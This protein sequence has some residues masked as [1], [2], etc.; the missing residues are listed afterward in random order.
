MK[1]SYLHKLLNKLYLLIK[2]VI[3]EFLRCS[4][5][6]TLSLNGIIASILWPLLG[7][8]TTLFT[9]KSF[10]LSLFSRFG[11]NNHSEFLI[12]LLTGFV[13]LSFYS[14]MTSQA[15]SIQADREDG[16]L[17]VIYIS[18]ANRF[19]LLLGRA[20]SGLPQILFSFVIIYC[21]IFLISSGNAF[22]KIV[23]Y[24]F[25]GV[26]LLI[27]A[28][29]WG[30]FM[31]SL[32]LVSRN[33]SIWYILFNTPMEYLS[34]VSIPIKSFPK[35][36]SVFSFIFPLTYTLDIVRTISILDCPSGKQW[37]LFIFI[38]LLCLVSTLFIIKKSEK[39][40]RKQGTLNLF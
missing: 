16:T 29:I 4:R 17:Q 24:M 22:I 12:F 10:N 5:L 9:Y 26:L 11:I 36:L 1:I 2:S 13:S 19:G 35:V 40:S 14:A 7:L 15:L 37:L 21:Y 25:A 33:T 18:P 34:G 38:N 27:S 23:F 20:L 30:T 3:A 39:N 8:L 31:C 6:N 32:Y 28:S